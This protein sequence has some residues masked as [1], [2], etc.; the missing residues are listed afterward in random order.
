MNEGIPR[1][2][3]TRRFDDFDSVRANVLNGVKNGY[4][5]RF[6][7]ENER[8]RLE[9]SNVAYPE[10]MYDVR[11][12]KKA[13]IEDS[14]L[15][16]PLFGKFTLIDKATNEPLDSVQGT[17]ARVPYLTHRGTYINNGNEYS[18]VA[19]QQRLKPGIYA[20]RK[21]NGEIESHF[22]LAS[23]TGQGLRLFM[24]PETGVYRIM[25]GKSRMRLYP[26]LKRM[27]VEDQE[28][29]KWWGKDVLEL[30]KK[31]DEKLFDKFYSKFMGRKSDTALDE[32][33][34]AMHLM[35]E[36]QK[37]EIDEEVAE[38]NLGTKFKNISP[39]VILRS[40]QKLLNIHRGL[41]QEDDRDSLANKL[42][43]GQEDLFEER[44]RK[45]VGSLAKKLLSRSS[46]NKKIT[47]WINGYFS[48]QLDGLVSGNSLSNHIDGINPIQI[49]D[50]GYRVVQTGEGA[51]EDSDAIPMQARALHPSQAG[52]I[53]FLRTPESQGAGVD[54]RFAFNTVKG[55]DRNVYV[56]LRNVK[57]GKI[58][59]LTP[60]QMSKKVV[61]FPKHK[62]LLPEVQPN[63]AGMLKIP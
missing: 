26:I 4:L 59:Y 61:G 50:F 5:S 13:L 11:D 6:P 63:A 60:A 36:L 15:T 45:D 1:G 21:D 31:D 54:Q 41:E 53:D 57:T 22:N 19:G 29:E 49:M 39:Q 9:L 46:Y 55:S 28:F 38:R 42:F 3:Q 27:G 47:G 14:S 10:K 20:R 35:E 32:K 33:G 23:G 48:P 40:S 12:E 24:E 16:V 43:V 8:Y 62:R 58:E 51:I 44:I 52:T 30:N 37:G 18:L 2:V 25:V 34:R 17:L 7:M 56:P